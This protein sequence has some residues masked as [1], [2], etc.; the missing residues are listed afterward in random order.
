[1]PWY[2]SN[3]RFV[4]GHPAISAVARLVISKRASFAEGPMPPQGSKDA[5]WKA[6]RALAHIGPS[7]SI[8]AASSCRLWRNTFLRTNGWWAS[9]KGCETVKSTA[10][11]APWSQ[12]MSKRKKFSNFERPKRPI[13]N[14]IIGPAE[15][16]MKQDCAHRA[17]GVDRE[18]RWLGER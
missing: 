7:D 15:S 13:H 8:F 18:S 10:V 1:M 14:A 3:T 2:I 11:S 12:F 17:E 4:F 16:K 6:Q 5:G 9:A